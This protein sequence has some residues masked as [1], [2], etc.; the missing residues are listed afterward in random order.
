MLHTMEVEI[1]ANGEIHPVKQGAKLP[2]GRAILAWPTPEEDVALLLS[3]LALSDW[4]R[5]EEDLAWAHI[6]PA[7]LDH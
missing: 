4:L 5:S 2:Q 3:E 7:K 1:D 6:Q